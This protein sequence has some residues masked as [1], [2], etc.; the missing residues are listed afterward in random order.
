MAA[1]EAGV[2]SFRFSTD[3]FPER[4][5]D[6]AWREFFGRKVARL[7]IEPLPDKPYR[8]S[9]SV[10]LLPDLAVIIG[11]CSGANYRLLRELIAGDDIAFVTSASD[12]WFTTQFG[13]EATLGKGDAVPLTNGEPGSITHGASTAPMSM[14]RFAC[15]SVPRKVLAALVPNLE[16]TLA[17]PIPARSEALRLLSGYLGL[18]ENPSAVTSP[19]LARLVATHV[20]DLVALAIGTTR[21]AAEIAQGRGVRAARLRAIKA[22]I[23]ANLGRGPLGLAMLAGRHRV[24]PRYIQKLFEG[25]GTTLSRF[26]LNQRL[27]R[28]YRRLTDPL[29]ANATIGALAF[30]A[31]FSDLSNFNHAFRRQ[32]GAAPSEV[33]RDAFVDHRHRAEAE[34]DLDMAR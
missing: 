26:V 20:H 16:D 30:D 22:D 28:V 34:I 12:N 15:F 23:A 27:T 2:A 11:D 21:E 17:R 31:G 18:L 14:S 5:R 24:S 33:R 7:D 3:D 32:F 10:R 19:E 9:A 4:D 29:C 1:G 25:E 8:A 6:A 13:R